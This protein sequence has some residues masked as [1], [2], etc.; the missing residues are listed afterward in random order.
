MNKQ[1]GE[2]KR[3]FAF[4]FPLL[5]EKNFVR[6]CAGKETNQNLSQMTGMG[7]IVTGPG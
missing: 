3:D 5:I 6:E 2:K 1:Q 4:F 7:N